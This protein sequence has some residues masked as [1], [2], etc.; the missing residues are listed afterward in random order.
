MADEEDL[1]HLIKMPPE[2]L[3]EIFRFLDFCTIFSK[4]IFTCKYFYK[5]LSSDDIWK[6]LFAMKW[7]ED[8]LINDL[9]Y[10][11]NRKDVCLCYEDIDKYWKS[12]KKN[13]IKLL[14]CKMGS[15]FAPVDDVH[16]MPDGRFCI[17]GSRD[18]SVILWDLQHFLSDEWCGE[19]PKSEIIQCHEGWVWSVGSSDQKPSVIV[20]SSWDQT[21]KEWDMESNLEMIGNHHYHPAAILDLHCHDNVYTT[22]CYD[23]IVRTYDPRS[24]DVVFQSKHH[25][26]AV[27][28]IKVTDKFILSGSEDETIGIFDVRASKLLTSLHVDSPVLCMN[29]AF[30]QGF[31]Y[32]RAG[33]RN[34]SL[35]VFD[36]T[37]DKFTLLNSVQLWEGHKLNQLC[38][39]QGVVA[40]CSSSGSI[41]MYSPDRTF[42]LFEK[43]DF[44]T[45]DVAGAHSRKGLLVTG[46]SDN[47]AIV[48]KFS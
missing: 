31:R 18:R 37:N 10:I 14:H 20:T 39:F 26:K 16:I 45:E 28:C 42:N 35:F 43:F 21:I 32:L 1:A 11:T 6:T 36:T 13:K 48:W 24:E 29:L 7:V 8:D 34:G 22:A 12:R 4:V 47:T 40:A 15:H 19:M 30:E 33:G 38:N 9:N 46:S 41:C 44:H 5:V 27:L 3:L 17:T 2:I 25:K 23:R